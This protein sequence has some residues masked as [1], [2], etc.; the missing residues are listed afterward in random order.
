MRRIGS[1]CLE[2]AVVNEDKWEGPEIRAFPVLAA[3]EERAVGSAASRKPLATR[4]TDA[5]RRAK[6]LGTRADPV[7]KLG[8]IDRKS[9]ELVVA[10]KQSQ[11]AWDSA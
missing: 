6:R 11:K 5:T 10:Q 4:K 3:S 8:Q 1:R 7:P 2:D 9:Q